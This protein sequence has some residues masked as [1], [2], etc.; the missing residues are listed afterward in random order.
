MAKSGVK[1]LL[2]F[3]RSRNDSNSLE[4]TAIVV[5]LGLGQ[6]VINAMARIILRQN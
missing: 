2:K 3:V 6:V 1:C 5:A 4:Y